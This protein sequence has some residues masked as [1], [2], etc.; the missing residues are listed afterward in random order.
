M[1]SEEAQ[2]SESVSD[3]EED[4]DEE[5]NSEVNSKFEFLG[6]LFCIVADSILKKENKHSPI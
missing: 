6:L 5:T 1:T 4:S 3:S 2:T